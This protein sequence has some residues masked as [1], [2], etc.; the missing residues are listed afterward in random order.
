MLGAAARAHRSGDVVGAGRLYE[1]ILAAVP[2]H[3]DAW[4]LWGV[5]AH[6]LGDHATALERIARA[7]TLHPHEARY[8]ANRAL[9][10]HALGRLIDAETSLRRALDLDPRNSANLF[11]LGNVLAAA[12]RPDEAADAYQHARDLDPENPRVVHNLAVALRESQRFDEA[13][14]AY[15]WL[16][17]LDSRNAEAHAGLA[18]VAHRLGKLDE[19]IDEYRVAVELGDGGRVADAVLAPFGTALLESGQA[20]EAMAVLQRAFAA[21]TT[22]EEDIC[23]CAL[24]FHRQGHLDQA[25]ALLRQSVEHRGDSARVT[26]MI[27]YFEAIRAPTA[28]A[29]DRIETLLGDPELAPDVARSLH[30]GLARL[31]DRSDRH[32]AAFEHALAGNALADATYDAEARREFVTE[33]R[34]AFSPDRLAAL[35]RAEPPSDLP[36]FIVGMPRSGTTLVEQILASHPLVFGADELPDIAAIARALPATVGSPEPYPQCMDALSPGVA[37]QLAQTYLDKLARLGGGASRVTDKL[38]HNFLYLGLIACLFPGARVIH[39]VRDPIDCGLS[40][41]FQDFDTV[42]RSYGV[43]LAHIGQELGQYHRLMRHW[44]ETLDLPILDVSYE[45]LVDDAEGIS[46]G[47]VAFC[48]LAWDDRCLRFNENPRVATSWSAADVRQ[49]LYR[50]S[51]GRAQY[52]G[53]RL[54]PLRR[55]LAAP[56]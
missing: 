39:C 33:S 50:H 17:A 40:T 29:L 9:A 19:A 34:A 14:E 16:V 38:P 7:I 21:P 18:V 36:V 23:R 54:D 6:Q 22:R 56:P 49:P 35:P 51:V 41:Y 55:A 52:Y 2:D 28:V 46:R 26:A 13:E 8:H 5:A 24:V 11:K 1:E 37:A 3:P 32:D 31:Y 20:D 27:T 30:L 48:G 10:F 12:K 44:R 15:R 42:G 47:M 53:D 4:H 25:I 43:D 45:A